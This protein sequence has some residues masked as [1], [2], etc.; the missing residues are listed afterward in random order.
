[1]PSKSTRIECIC[2]N[3]SKTFLAKRSVVAI[4]QAKFCNRA[5]YLVGRITPPEI[6]FWKFV[7][8]TESCWLWTGNKSNWNY[9][10]FKAGEKDTYSHRFSWILHHGPIPEGM[11]VLHR[12]D[13]PPCINPDHLF[14]GTFADN[15]HDMHKKGRANTSKGSQHCHAKL[16]ESQVAEIRRR[17]ALGNITQSELGAEFGVHR[18]SIRR[19]IKRK[20]WVHVS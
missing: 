8:K 10:L 11:C 2:Q 19:I 5:C 7:Q 4:G 18:V 16:T 6:R 17:Y 15:T 20:V 9:G 13:N 1:M 14:L 3:C 12:C